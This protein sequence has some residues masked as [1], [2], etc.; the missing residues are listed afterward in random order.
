MES[1]K[2][3]FKIGYGPSSSHTMGPAIASKKFLDKNIDADSFKCYLYGSLA[4]TGKGHLTDYIIKKTFNNKKIDIIFDY[5]THY[6]YHP[7]GMKFVAYKDEQIVDEWLVFSVGGGSIKELGDDRE[8]FTNEVYPHK[9]MNAILDYTKKTNM[10]L[11]DY[12]LKYETTSIVEHLKKCLM[13]MKETLNKGLF[14]DGILPGGLNVT[15]KASSFYQ[16]YL[17]NPSMEAL[18]FAYALAIAEENASGNVVV[19]APTCG[20]CGVVPA[21]LLSYQKMNNVS[22]EKIIEALMVAG[23]IG[24]I[25]K[26]NAS[27]SGAEVGCQGE[28]GVACSMAAAA[29]AYLNNNSNE[30]IEYAAEVALEH[31]L[32]M[33][34]DPVDGLV[35][36]P[37]IE[38]NAVSAM[39]AHNVCKYVELAGNAH[40]ITLDSVIEVMEATGKD[41]HAKYRETSTGGLALHNRG[42]Y[43]NK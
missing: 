19:T 7:N 29:L 2:E 10:S 39:Q 15:R 4:S 25:A 12:V 43:D 8:T 27:I 18:T 1:I 3:I 21:V 31:H 41:L 13:L 33:T 24:N 34:C 36:I 22:D 5:K 35:Q 32:G 37:C 28:I 11:A 17:S 9:R 16:K 6:D 20:S 14:T 38:R 26:T 30:G 42:I 23:L 40:N